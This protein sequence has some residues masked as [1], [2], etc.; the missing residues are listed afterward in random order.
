MEFHNYSSI[1]NWQIRGTQRPEF[2]EW[3]RKQS[4]EQYRL[5]LA[6]QALRDHRQAR[7]PET[8]STQYTTLAI[9]KGEQ[10][11]VTHERPFYNVWP[12]AADLS[13]SVKL[14]IPFSAVATPF[15]AMLLRFPQG[16][17]PHGVATCLLYFPEDFPCLLVL[18][19]FAHRQQRWSMIY[20]FIP[21]D[22]VEDVLN[23]IE[24]GNAPKYNKA[25]SS[26]QLEAADAF[27]IRLVVFIGLLANGRDLI[28]PIVLTKDREKYEST[29]AAD[30]KTWLEDR[31][32]RKMGRGFDV[33]RALE[34]ER[35]RS[36]HWRNPHLA[37]FWTGPGRATPIIK[38]R[39]GAVV[40]R[41][42]MA[43][44]PTGYLGSETDADDK[45]PDDKTQ[46]E[47]ISKSRRFIIMQR[48]TFTCQLCGAS[49]GNG[50][51]LHVDHMIPLARGGSNDDDNLWTLCEAC[52]LGKSDRLI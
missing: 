12:V 2:A 29:D 20:D 42:S 46:R 49:R 15:K 34:I 26:E 47:A 31:A 21:G 44:V 17:E 22:T 50:A 7:S 28:T 11:W 1:R 32:A 43:D 38:M 14:A 5:W 30:V 18:A 16:R 24:S 39:R 27:L 25:A 33:G 52:N 36:P 9:A 51:K 4:S 48:D 6:N 37:L 35:E 23:D 19:S 45:L 40:Q 41:V 8:K 13:Q 10:E 3:L